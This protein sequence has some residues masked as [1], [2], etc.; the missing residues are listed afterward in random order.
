MIIL[1]TEKEIKLMRRAGRIVAEVLGALKDAVKANVPTIYYAQLAEKITAKMGGSPAFKGYRGFPAPLCVSIND[2]V[3]HGI[4][5]KDRVLK[6]GDIVSF[7]FGAVYRGFYADGALTVAVGEVNGKV[8]ELIKVTEG[9]FWEALKFARVGNHLG[10]ISHAIQRFVES[11]GFSV[12][13][14]FVG[15]GIGRSLHEDPPVPNYGER[16][17]PPLLQPGMTLAIEPMVNMG[18]FEVKI[19]EDGWTSKTKD[20][21]FSAHYEHTVA[22]TENGPEILTSF[23]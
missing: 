15:H 12:V 7:D 2:E 17:T 1:K 22:I 9:A 3:V 20:G 23:D 16:G 10:D 4:P 5:A 14:D 21:S 8:K 6:E 13:R 11:K 19:M 18:G